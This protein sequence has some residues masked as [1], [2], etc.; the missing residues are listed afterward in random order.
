MEKDIE[1]LALS[2]LLPLGALTVDMCEAI[3]RGNAKTV[4]YCDDKAVLLRHRCGIYMLW[5]ADKINGVKALDALDEEARENMRCCLCHGMHA[6]EAAEERTQLH[7]D[8]PC[9]QFYHNSKEKMPL[10]GEY[11]IRRMTEADLPF[12]NANYD[13]EGEKH[14]AWAVREG[15]VFAAEIG[16]EIA[17]FIGMHPDGS[18]GMLKVMQSFRRR[19]LGT[20]MEKYMHNVHIERGWVC[21]GH[22]FAD[23]AASIAVQEKQGLEKSSDYLYW[24]FKKDVDPKEFWDI[25]I[26]G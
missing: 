22:V 15:C 24:S 16:G 1:K 26:G 4:I 17:A 10:S 7:I 20:E 6:R 13:M 14:N 11:S 5:C 21:Y 9:L 19:G 2:V 3:V 8:A 25:E 12:L 18:T 23:N